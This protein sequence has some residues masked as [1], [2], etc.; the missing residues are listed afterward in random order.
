[1]SQRIACELKT[2]EEFKRFVLDNKYVIVKGT[3]SWC[4]PC[5]RIKP[6]IIKL[7]NEMPINVAFAIIDISA[8]PELKSFLRI[9]SVPYIMNYICGEKQDVINTSRP[10]AINNFFIKTFKRVQN[11]K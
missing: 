7:I 11:G 6:L 10:E 9:N 2:I 3:A 8:S 1:M 5:Q 4:G